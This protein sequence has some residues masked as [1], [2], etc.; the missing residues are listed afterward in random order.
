MNEIVQVAYSS[1]SGAI[2]P[3][4]QWHEEIVITR[5]KV[6]FRRRGR[7]EDSEINAGA[8]EFEVDEGEVSDLF[9][10]L[11]AI[12]CSAITRVAPDDPLDGGDT[13]SYA[14]LYTS[15]MR[16]SLTYDPGTTYTNGESVTTPIKAFIQSLRLPAG[17]APRYISAC[18]GYD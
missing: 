15:G 14:I 16:R 7:E 9:Q 1:D 2:L 8:W 13:E 10:Q 17:A 6:I 12:D 3:E 11:E 4:L 5:N 18:A